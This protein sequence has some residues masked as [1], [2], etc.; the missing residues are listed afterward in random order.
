MHLFIFFKNIFNKHYVANLT[1]YRQNDCTLSQKAVVTKFL[2]DENNKI[3][4][5]KEKRYKG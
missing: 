4:W 3:L 1:S 2:F 5:V